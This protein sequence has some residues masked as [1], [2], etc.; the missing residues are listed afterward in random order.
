[1][2]SYSNDLSNGSRLLASYKAIRTSWR[3]A[4]TGS[5]PPRYESALLSSAMDHAMFTRATQGLSPDPGPHHPVPV[6]T[7]RCLLLEL[8]HTF[9]LPS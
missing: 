8:L 9:R 5:L 6:S 2:L 7:P 4:V 3:V 1:M